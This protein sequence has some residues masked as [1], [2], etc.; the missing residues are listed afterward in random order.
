[1][2]AYALRHGFDGERGEFF[3]T[4]PFDAPADRH[5]K[6]WW[7]K[8]EGWS[9]PYTYIFSPRRRL[10]RVFLLTVSHRR[11]ARPV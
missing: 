5:D 10:L 3:D 9:A 6:I 4:G 2:F 11:V 7:V 1:M 8:A